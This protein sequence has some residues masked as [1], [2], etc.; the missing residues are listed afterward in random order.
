[1]ARHKQ[2]QSLGEVTTR[3]DPSLLANNK[4]TPL[5]EGGR[6]G[7]FKAKLLQTAYSCASC[8]DNALR[9]CIE[10]YNI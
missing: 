3:S 7:N 6:V 9:Q 4:Q 5:P 8:Q 1:M 10:I 2:C